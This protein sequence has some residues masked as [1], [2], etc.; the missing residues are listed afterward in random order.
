MSE[1]SQEQRKNA[2]TTLA[3]TT[4]QLSELDKETPSLARTILAPDAFAAALAAVPAEDWSRTWAA[5]RTIMLR[6]TSKTVKEVV[7]KMRP[8]SVVRLSR[9]FWNDTRNG[10]AAERLQFVLRHTTALTA[11]CCITTLAL[12]HCAMKEQDAGRLAGVL[13]QCPALAH[14]NLGFNGIGAAG[15]GS[16]AGVLR[17]CA[18]LAHLNLSFNQIGAAGAG[19]LSQEC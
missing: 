4:E 17:Q 2:R 9:S 19:S 11:W 1:R 7:D 8:P 12:P 13:V 3:T 10:T 5:N 6:M 15:A 16:L 18:A 14:L